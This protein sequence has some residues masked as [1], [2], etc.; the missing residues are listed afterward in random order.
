[1]TFGPVFIP[2]KKKNLLNKYYQF[3]NVKEWLS[4]G[5]N[6]WG[7]VYVFSLDHDTQDWNTSLWF[8]YSWKNQS[9]YLSL[10]G[11]CHG[12]LHSWTH[13]GC[14]PNKCRWSESPSKAAV[15]IQVLCPQDNY[16]MAMMKSTSAQSWM[17]TGWVPHTSWHTWFWHSDLYCTEKK[18][19]IWNFRFTILSR[20]PINWQK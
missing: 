6:I 15:L 16:M 10:Y 1:M 8:K 20:W 9:P 17:K 14:Y 4:M 18:K 2:P 3:N 12:W 19:P 5:K 13:L 7:A 11:C